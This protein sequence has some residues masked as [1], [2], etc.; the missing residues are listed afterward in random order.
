MFFK[1][2]LIDILIMAGYLGFISWIGFRLWRQRSLTAGAAGYLLAGRRLTLPTFVATLVSTY[3]GGVFGVGEFSYL[4]GISNWLVFGIPYYLAALI[5]ALFIA[6]KARRQELYTIPQQLERSYGKTASLL[7]AVF[8]FLLSLPAAYILMLAVLLQFLFGWSILTGLI[9]GT[10]VSTL[11]VFVGGFNSVVKTDVV[12]FSLMFLGF[13]IILPMAY[14]QYG[15]WEFLATHAPATHFVWHGGNGVQY[16]V[17]WYFIDLSTLVEPS[18]YQRCFAAKD[19]KTAQRG[20]L[21]SILFW[22]VFDFLTTFTGM[23]ARAILPNLENP[24]TS[25]LA[26]GAE[27]LPPVALGLFFTGLLATIM[28]SID[29]Y[30]FLAAGTLGRDVLWRTLA[31]KNEDRVLYYTRWGLVFSAILSVGLAYLLQ[32]V[33]DIWKDVGSIATPALLLPL[34]TSFTE[35]YRLRS[36]AAVISIIGSALISLVWLFSRTFEGGNGIGQYWLNIEPVFPG[37]LFSLLVFFIDRVRFSR[38]L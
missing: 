23:Y 21:I 24:M 4:Y 22:I 30:S 19:E 14:F 37:L 13:L 28:S 8:V 38:R 26:L 20:I 18:F 27:V 17:V 3:Y 6:K 34:M 9:L 33:I 1:L 31:P 7:G 10:M 15:G 35:K 2:S 29:S 16:I 36:R 32:S 11:Y 12:Q 5:F 25:Y